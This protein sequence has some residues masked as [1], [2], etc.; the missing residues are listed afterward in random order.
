MEFQFDALVVDKMGNSALGGM[1]FLISNRIITYAAA[2]TLEVQR[3]HGTYKYRFDSSD[4]YVNPLKSSLLRVSSSRTVLPGD[5]LKLELD[6][7]S[8]LQFVY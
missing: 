2:G 5:F 6:N 3:N 4:K 1:P 7:I 8:R